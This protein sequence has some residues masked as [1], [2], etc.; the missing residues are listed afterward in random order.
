MAEPAAI[1]H[2]IVMVDIDKIKLDPT[3]PNVMTEAQLDALCKNLTNE[4]IGDVNPIKLNKDHTVI[5]GEHRVKAYK[6]L[7]VKQVP[8]IVLNLSK[9]EL[10]MQ[11]QILNKL[12]GEHDPQK[13]LADYIII[14]NEG[15]LKQFAESLGKAEDDFLKIL[16]R[17]DSGTTEVSFQA[18]NHK[19]PKCG[20]EF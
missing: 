6:R 17:E 1:V 7:G 16:N 11:R 8:C 20:H 15:L 12:H 4:K 18:T 2:E 9:T 19:C 5:D 14:Q 13:D 10:K 3:N